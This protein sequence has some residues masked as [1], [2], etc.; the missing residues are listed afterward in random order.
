MV[1]QYVLHDG[2]DLRETR[3]TY[4]SSLYKGVMKKMHSFKESLM[5]KVWAEDRFLVGQVVW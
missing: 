5:I 3:G 4:G 1:S 2:W